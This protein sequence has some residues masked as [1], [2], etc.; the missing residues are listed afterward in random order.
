MP[1]LRERREN[2]W[3][4]RREAGLIEVYRLPISW[5]GAPIVI[6]RGE[7]RAFSSGLGPFSGVSLALS[8]LVLRHSAHAAKLDFRL[9]LAADILS[10]SSGEATR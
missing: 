4:A 2:G 7:L 8:N 3:P 6:F 9:S 1:L 5:T 10:P